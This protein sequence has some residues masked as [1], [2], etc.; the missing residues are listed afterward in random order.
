MSETPEKPAK[1]VKTS[2]ADQPAA[3]DKA[4]KAA[5]P[6]KPAP[7]PKL[8]DKPFAAFINDDLIPALNQ[9]LADRNQSPISLELVEGDRPV[10][11]GNCWM[12]K[13]VLP[14][15]RRFWLCFENDSITSGKTIALAESGSDP[16]L[17]ESFLIDEKRITLALLES[18]LLQ[19]LNGQKWFGGN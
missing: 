13:G 7:K 9:S 18:R 3:T 10:V 6:A 12:I 14:S 4:N 8:E 17:L 5:K 1:A 19:R 2:Q 16:S 11:G 15:E